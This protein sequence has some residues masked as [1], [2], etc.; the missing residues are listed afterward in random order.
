ML[1]RW[2]RSRHRTFAFV[3]QT[4]DVRAGRLTSLGI[5]SGVRERSLEANTRARAHSG[6]AYARTSRCLTATT[7]DLRAKIHIQRKALQAALINNR[8]SAL[9]SAMIRQLLRMTALRKISGALRV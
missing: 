8:H 9:R 1:L 3:P 7:T 4:M 6:R 5:T 2:S